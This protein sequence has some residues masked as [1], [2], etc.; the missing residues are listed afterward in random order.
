MISPAQVRGARAMLRLTVVALGRLADIAPNTVVRVEAEH[1]VNTAT[2]KALQ[3]A[4]EDAGARFTP[5]GGVCL[6]VPP[7]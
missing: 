5:D 6:R 1:S 7:E 4:L 3:A 2:L